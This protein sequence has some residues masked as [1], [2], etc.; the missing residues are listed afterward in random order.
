MLQTST[1][2]KSTLE[3]LS[4]LQGEKLLSSAR[5]VGGTALSLQIG[6][7]ESVDLDLFSTE[8]LEM[9]S[10]QTLLIEKYGFVPSVIADNTLIGF[11]HGVKIDVIY[12]LFHLITPWFLRP[13]SAHY[14]CLSQ[15]HNYITSISSRSHHSGCKVIRSIGKQI[16]NALTAHRRAKNID[17][18]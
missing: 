15:G 4:Q 10:V 5:L 11:I 13:T 6:H 1:I 12:Q 3:L 14:G 9:M 2:K 16:P 7:R 17:A 8:P 18:R